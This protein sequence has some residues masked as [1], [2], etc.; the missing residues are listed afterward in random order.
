LAREDFSG[1]AVEEVACTAAGR[2]VIGAASAADQRA[3]LGLAIGTD[4]L[5]YDPTLGALAALTVAA[6]SLTVGT[7]ADAFSQ[8]A[9]AAISVGATSPSNSMNRT[10]RISA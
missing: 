5:A 10:R 1:T 8:V 7:G 3:A 4:V 6:N 9:F 2:A